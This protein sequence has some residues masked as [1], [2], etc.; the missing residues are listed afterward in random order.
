V[1]PTDDD[2]YAALDTVVKAKLQERECV[3][4]K[5]PTCQGQSYETLDAWFREA[6]VEDLSKSQFATPSLALIQLQGATSRL[7]LLV[8]SSRQL[9]ASQLTVSCLSHTGRNGCGFLVMR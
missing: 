2:V 6:G 7:P 5:V 4:R 1:P 3:R 8:R 9:S